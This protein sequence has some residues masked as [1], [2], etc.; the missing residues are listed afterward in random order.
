M[1]TKLKKTKTIKTE[2]DSVQLYR[3]RGAILRLDKQG[4]PV[5][6]VALDL[7]DEDIPAEVAAAIEEI[8]RAKEED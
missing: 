1:A 8:Q 3:L 7:E 5:G 4:K 2:V 6:E